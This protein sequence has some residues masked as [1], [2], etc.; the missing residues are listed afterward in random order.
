MEE[1]L[2]QLE[3][4]TYLTYEGLLDLYRDYRNPKDK[5][6]NL[7][8]KRELR[9]VKRDL[10]LLGS[11]YRPSYS[12]V[13]LANLIYGPSAVSFESALEYHG[14]IP[15][16]VEGVYSICFKRKKRFETPL[17][18]FV[19]RYISPESFPVG[20]AHHQSAEGNFLMASK[21]KALCDIA[22]FTHLNS[23]QDAVKWVLE[24]LRID[25]DELSHLDSSLLSEIS[26]T[27]RKKSVSHLIQGI[28]TFREGKKG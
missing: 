25:Q 4:P 16:R 3:Q 11:H 28:L 19:Y 26:K 9:R 14:L 18:T 24:E 2:A 22:Y 5:V 7:L 15:E 27:Y 17:G 20:I 1:R 10:Y 6:K 8:K 23:D 13:V 21:E 12:K